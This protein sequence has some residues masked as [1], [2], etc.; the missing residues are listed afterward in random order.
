MPEGEAV[1]IQSQPVQSLARIDAQALIT[2]ALESG[3]HVDTLERLVALAKDMRQVQAREAWHE[4]MAR[5]QAG[6]PKILKTS[7]ARIATR[8]GV[9]YSYRFASLD[10][11][12][13]TVTPL[14]SDLGLSVSWKSAVKA[15][16]V[17]V[18]CRIAHA[19]GHVEDA[20]EVE[21]P[22][23]SGDTGA[24]P[25]QRVGIALT[26]A[27]R[28]ALMNALGIAPEDD[29]DGG[30]HDVKHRDQATRRERDEEIVPRE[31]AAGDVRTEM[32]DEIRALAT[33]IKLSAD[34][35]K[36]AWTTYV[37]DGVKPEEADPAALSGL[38]DWLRTR[39]A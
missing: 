5:F 2:K 39:A 27:R 30:S 37:G 12:M 8:G 17:I 33:R 16:A 3:A 6:C 24:N 32:L 25:A 38:I 36:T 13:S 14:L 26:Y 28:Y 23:V 9:G 10:E 31:P 15:N 1:V 34:D 29:D 7:S 21:M 20:G 18:S 35:R 11:I 19:L 4:A 22:V